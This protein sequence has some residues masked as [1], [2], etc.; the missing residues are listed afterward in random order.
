MGRQQE[1]Y[2]ELF[3]RINFEKIKDHP[4]IL[5]AANFWNKER[6]E[7]ARTFY[8]FMRSIDDLLITTNHPFSAFPRM[9]K[10]SLPEMWS[11][12]LRWSGTQQKKIPFTWN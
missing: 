3:N 5:I 12:G 2:L 4:N 7:A 6:Y 11:S 9:K 8:R 10:S 1:E